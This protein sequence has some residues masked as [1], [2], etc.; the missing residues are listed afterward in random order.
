MKT[1]LA[2]LVTAIG[3]LA[4]GVSVFYFYGYKDSFWVQGSAYL[5]VVFG[6]LSLLFLAIFLHPRKPKA[7]QPG[8]HTWQRIT[9]AVYFIIYPVLLAGL[10]GLFAGLEMAKDKRVDTLLSN[11]DSKRA[12]AIVT[13]REER[14]W[15]TSHHTYAIISYSTT[16]GIVEQ[17]IKDDDGMYQAGQRIP[18]TYSPDYPDM[19]RVEAPSASESHYP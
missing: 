8:S 2:L 12:I 3:L 13:E 4:A 1:V 6:W 9:Y 7:E 14:R 5:P 17:A 18:I 10:V 15:R 19:F 11:P 16:D